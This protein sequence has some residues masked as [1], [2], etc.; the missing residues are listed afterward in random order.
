MSDLLIRSLD[1]RLRRQLEESARKNRHSLSEEAKRLIRRGLGAAAE[2]D[3]RKLGT[4]LSG[5]LPP[6]YRSDDYVFEIPGEV[7]RP[8]DFK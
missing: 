5:L 6:E 4:F 3:D 1:V 2:P 8:P 7:S